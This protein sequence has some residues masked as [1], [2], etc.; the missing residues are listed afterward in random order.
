MMKHEVII[1]LGSNVGS[2]YLAKSRQFLREYV[3]IMQAT[4][5]ITTKPIGMKSADFHNQML[6]GTTELT[7][8]ELTLNT[9]KTEAALGRQHG[10]GIVSIDID[11]MQYDDTILHPDDWQRDYIKELYCQIKK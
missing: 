1:A 8:D 4:G 2:H 10:K 6:I 9:K 3:N 5:I 7:L 11:L